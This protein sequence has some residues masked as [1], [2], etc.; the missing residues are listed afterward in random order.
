[1]LLLLREESPA[2]SSSSSALLRDAM[3]NSS[4]I[5]ST[6]YD[7]NKEENADVPISY[8][9]IRQISILGERN[10]GTRWTFE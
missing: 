4:T 6:S 2:R 1:M 10:S 5:T 9:P 8:N 3:T 7:E